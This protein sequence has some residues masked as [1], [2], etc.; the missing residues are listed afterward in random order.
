MNFLSSISK[1]RF[2]MLI[3]ALL[4]ASPVFA[5]NGGGGY[6]IGVVDLE[7]VFENYEKQKDR[8]SELVKER[9]KLQQPITE[10]SD[11]ITKDKERYEKESE[12]MSE[13]ARIA[14]RDQIESDFAKYN[15]EV[16]RSQQEI[17]R[18]EKRIVEELIKDIQQAVEVVGA[19][20]NYHLIFDGAK[21]NKNNLLYYDTTMNMTPKVVSYLNANY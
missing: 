19:Q 11:K 21:T 13:D 12:S 15:A 4:I 6:K 3:V 9:D 2:G 18:R 20:E 16:Q 8:Y 1:A 5:Q 10:L 17:D 14:L 7:N